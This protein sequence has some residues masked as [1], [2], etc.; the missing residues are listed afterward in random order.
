MLAQ[1]LKILHLVRTEPIRIERFDPDLQQAK[2]RLAR[3]EA[4]LLPP[5]QHPHSKH[6]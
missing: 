2:D 3:L 6:A 1:L 5:A 4:L